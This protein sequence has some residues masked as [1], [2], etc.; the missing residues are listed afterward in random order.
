MDNEEKAIRISSGSMV[1]FVVILLLFAALYFLRDLI[2]I[3][4]AA[5]VI[6]SAIEPATKWFG[7]IKIPRLPAVIIVYLCVFAITVGVFYFFVP[8]IINEI[9]D[10][11]ERAP[12]FI[13]SLGAWGTEN[14]GGIIGDSVSKGNVSPLSITEVLTYFQSVVSNL[15]SNIFGVLSKIFGGV[16]SFALIVVISFYLSVQEHGIANFLRIITPIKHENYVIDLWTRSQRK[17]GRWMQGEL[18]LMLI[19]GVLVFLGLTILGVKH[20]LVLAVMAA[21][22]ELIPLFGPILSSIPAISL[23]FV[24]GGIT[25]SLM[26][27]GLYIIVQQFENYLIY[28]LVVKKVTGMPA[29]IVIISLIIGVELAG[30]IGAI[31]SVPIAAVFMEYA[32]DIDKRKKQLY[33]H[34]N[35]SKITD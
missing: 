14:I 25:L 27:I 32:D 6:A 2:L 4:I 21:M 13:R 10:M 33:N 23:A 8:L 20:A 9:L 19:V 7:K 24:D 35:S 28:P 1:R 11:V 29:I 18:L 16:L 26:V 3:I 31:L 5:V 30:F 34:V 22:F 17:I 15:S 12:D